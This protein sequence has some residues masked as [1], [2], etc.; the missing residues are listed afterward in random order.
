MEKISVIIPV[1]NVKQYLERCIES[2][3]GQTYSNMEIIIVDDGS[4]DGSEVL[5]DRYAKV[6][7]RIKVIHKKN[8]GLSDARNV[9]MR[10]ATGEYIAF[11]DSDDWIDFDYYEVLYNKLKT[12]DSEIAIIGFL[13]VEGDKFVKPKFYLEDQRMTSKEAISELAKDELL[14]SHAWN[15]LFK[16]DLF[17]EIDFPKGKSYEDIFIMHK[18]FKKAKNVVIISD[19][20][21]YYFMHDKSIIH[22]LS[23]KNKLDEFFAFKTRYEDLKSEYSDIESIMANLACDRARSVYC[24]IAISKKEKKLYKGELKE[25]KK[26]IKNKKIIKKVE[27]K[28][29]VLSLSPKLYN[30]A[31]KIKR[32]IPQYVKENIRSIRFS[33]K[34]FNKLDKFDKF[35]NR[36]ILMGGPEYGNMGDLA[37][38][39]FTRT[40]VE[41][42]S[43]KKFIEITEKELNKS[44]NFIKT[45]IKSEDI[46]LLQGG[47]NM[48]SEYKDQEKIRDAIISNFPKNKIIIMP[49]TIYFSNDNYGEKM[50]AQMQ[51]KYSTHKDLNIFSRESISFNTMNKIFRNNINLVPDI[52]M[53]STMKFSFYER[54]GAMICLRSD[55]EGVLRVNDLMKI[56]RTIFN[57]FN[58]Y[59][60]IDTVYNDDITLEYREQVLKDF[61]L[62]MQKVELVVT[63]RLHGMIFAAITGTPCIVI[64]NYNHKVKEC[65][66]W[67]SE[68]EYIKFCDT[69]DK[70]EMKINEIDFSKKYIY[71]GDKFMDKFEKM[72]LLFV[73]KSAI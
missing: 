42:N 71:P 11:L 67:F 8:G 45:K 53:S 12:T 47:G 9:G 43:D 14:T 15:K 60:F 73:E 58:R 13:W 62:K 27:I 72:K 56:K 54:R 21:S 38:A 57:R 44:L 33:K 36:V 17:K 20:K 26:F 18:I 7:N 41:C 50:K 65:Y 16:R 31:C 69:I 46:L 37:I 3:I 49:Q 63:D 5:C 32:K 55:V 59:F 6:D 68:L 35:E 30:I 25:V 34:K 1:Y 52:V 19:Y 64:G 66:A 51:E 70:I 22:T 28:Y 10:I 48:G 23:L 24:D 4:S 39:H 2:V 40:F 61:W 29:K